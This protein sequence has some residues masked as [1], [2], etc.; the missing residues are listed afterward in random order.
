[1]SIF[2]HWL[3]HSAHLQS[4]LQRRFQAVSQNTL[5][6]ITYSFFLGCGPKAEG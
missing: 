5:A 2:L 4:R 3:H 1:M 6:H